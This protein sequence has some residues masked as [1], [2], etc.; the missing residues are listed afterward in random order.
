MIGSLPRPG[1]RFGLTIAVLSTAAIMGLDAASPDAALP[2]RLRAAA[3]VA[4]GPVLTTIADAFPAPSDAERARTEAETRLALAQDEARRL[5]GAAAL[6][7]SAALTPL[8]EQGEQLVLAR[9]IA[10]GGLGS[11]G[12]ERLT[13]D[14]GSA[15]GIAEDQS[16]VAAA[17]L[18]GRTVRVGPST[19]DVLI[20]GAADLVVGAR[21]TPGDLLGTVSPPGTDG[22]PRSAGQLTFTAIAFGDLA[23]GEQLVTVGSPG[24]APFVAGIPI[25][26]VA[27]V[28]PAA[29]RVGV[30]AAITPAVDIAT[31][32]IVAVIVP[33][34]A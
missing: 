29:G 3:A 20:L 31:L 15:D 4:T 22:A 25:G 2:E 16:V 11:D 23:E 18:V 12:P 32:D 14:V 27:E 13:I 30:S 17:G 10:V 24:S 34:G 9:V 28:D 7:D 8:R 1:R 33:G 21:T 19:S 5:R 6:A 26:S